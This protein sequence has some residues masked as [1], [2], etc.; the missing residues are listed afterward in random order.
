M[1]TFVL[2]PADGE[3]EFKANAW[4]IRGA[5]TITGSWSKDED[6]VTEVQVQDVV[7]KVPKRILVR[8]LRRPIPCRS[9]RPDRCLGR[10][11]GEM[12]FRRIISRFI[13]VSGNGWTT[14]IA[15]C[16]DSQLRLC[17]T[18]FVAHVGPG[19]TLHNVGKID[20]RRSPWASATGSSGRR[21]TTRSLY[22]TVLLQCD[23]QQPTPASTSPG[24]VAQLHMRRYT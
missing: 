8:I 18:T 17:A 23:R 12:E 19:P 1:I 4:S 11:A 6:N 15:R 16:G 7:P 2:E 10:L 20:R 14:S 21:S 13:L 5:F 3:H 9:R 24:S 22:S